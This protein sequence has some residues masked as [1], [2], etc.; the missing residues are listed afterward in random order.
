MQQ[1]LRRFQSSFITR[2]KRRLL[3]STPSSIMNKKKKQPPSHLQLGD[4]VESGGVIGGIGS[5]VINFPLVSNSPTIPTRTPA[6]IN[7][8]KLNASPTH[9][10]KQ[11]ATMFGTSITGSDGQV[12]Y[13]PD[14]Q[15][16]IGALPAPLQPQ[17]S[18]WIGADGTVQQ[19]QQFVDQQFAQQQQQ[20][21]QQVPAT[22]QAASGSRFPPSVSASLS[23]LLA[24]L[25]M[26][27]GRSS[28]QTRQQQSQQLPQTQQSTKQL[29]GM[30]TMPTIP[31]TNIMP[32]SSKSGQPQQTVPETTEAMVMKRELPQPPQ[33][34]YQATVG[35]SQPGQTSQSTFMRQQT[36]V[37]W[38]EE[39][40]TTQTEYDVAAAT[41]SASG[42]LPSISSVPQAIPEPLV[43][44]ISGPSYHHPHLHQLAP[45]QESLQ[46]AGRILPQPGGG[47]GFNNVQTTQTGESTIMKR[48]I[49]FPVMRSAAMARERMKI[50][51]STWTDETYGGGS[52]DSRG[53]ISTGPRRRQPPIPNTTLLKRPSSAGVLMSGVT[54]PS[55]ATI[56]HHRSQL[57]QL[58]QQQSAGVATYHH[59]HQKFMMG[60]GTHPGTS[61]RRITPPVSRARRKPPPLHQQ[62]QH[63]FHSDGAEEGSSRH[64]RHGDYGYDVVDDEDED[65]D[66]EDWC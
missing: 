50:R 60:F 54:A 38:P 39:I 64:R 36:L 47:G 29:D 58:H 30:A 21:G 7:F 35:S 20:S 57:K 13:V 17:P 28:S 10:M 46:G 18:V 37:T 41:A 63:S 11:H 5:L 56:R 12:L 44:P 16:L 33:L 65:D 43:E 8:P 48:S 14:E 3:P 25:R 59:P 22:D 53:G 32:Q 26:F 31:T 27:G 1:Q 19:E 42:T 66:G 4:P 23:S 62:H 51:S 45:S 61:S 15:Q 40:V 9:Y 55:V 2:A 24:P 52:E 34:T 49:E 6:N